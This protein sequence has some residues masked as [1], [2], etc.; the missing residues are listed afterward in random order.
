MAPIPMRRAALPALLVSALLSSLAAPPNARAQATATALPDAPRAVQIA[1]PLIMEG[2]KSLYQR[3]LARPGAVLHE[4]P[5]SAATKQDTPPF[6]MF[7]VYGK[8]RIGE[9]DWLHVG[10]DTRGDLSGWMR[11]DQTLPWNQALTVAFREPLGHDRVMLFRDKGALKE[12]VSKHDLIG[13]RKLYTKAEGGLADPDSPVVAIQPE[14]HIDIKDNFYLVPIKRHEDMFLAGQ[15]ARMLQ[16]TSVPLDVGTQSAPADVPGTATAPQTG[17]EGGAP[18]PVPPGGYRT[19]LVF[20]VDSTI[21]MGP[22]I[23][24]TRSVMEKVYSAIDSAG[25]TDRVSFG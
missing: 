8:R 24:R 9:L 25:L 7:Y 4:S 11:A 12:L 2:K 6:R 21:S 22:Y 10:N 14:G 20:V 1:E 16:V 13:Y 3:V 5:D 15:R 19:G 18:Q 17:T 23:N